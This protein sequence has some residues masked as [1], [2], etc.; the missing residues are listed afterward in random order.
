MAVK[1]NSERYYV[2]FE[3][4]GPEYINAR[5]A[6]MIVREIYPDQYKPNENENSLEDRSVN[7][8]GLRTY[9]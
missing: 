1:V 6:S 8:G 5:E 9:Y 3:V 2:I 4:S 7:F